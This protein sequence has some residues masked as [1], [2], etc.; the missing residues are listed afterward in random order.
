MAHGL[1]LIVLAPVPHPVPPLN[2]RL[3]CL[4]RHYSRPELGAERASPIAPVLIVLVPLRSV[5]RP[6]PQ[7][8]PLPSRPTD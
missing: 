7:H 4:A 6:V 3:G 2:M 1:E 5:I 8:R